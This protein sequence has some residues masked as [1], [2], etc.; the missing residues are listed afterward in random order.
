MGLQEDLENKLKAALRDPEKNQSYRY[1]GTTGDTTA[2]IALIERDIRAAIAANVPEL[3]LLSVAAKA[4]NGR[5]SYELNLDSLVRVLGYDG[6]VK[7]DGV[8]QYRGYIYR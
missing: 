5:I 6:S 7:Y 2:T 1:L 3:R 8:A 4:D